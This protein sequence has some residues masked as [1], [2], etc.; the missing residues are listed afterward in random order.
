MIFNNGE[1]TEKLHLTP[2]LKTLT[3]FELLKPVLITF[4]WKFFFKTLGIFGDAKFWA[5]FFIN[6]T[7]FSKFYHSIPSRHSVGSFGT[8]FLH[9]NPVN[10]CFFCRLFPWWWRIRFFCLNFPCNLPAIIPA[11]IH[12]VH[13]R[14]YKICKTTRQ[15]IEIDWKSIG[16]WLK[17]FEIVWKSFEIVW[18][19]LESIGNCL[20]SIGNR[21]EIGLKSIEIDWKSFEKNLNFFLFYFLKIFHYIYFKFD[22]LKI[23]RFSMK[24][25]QILFSFCFSSIGSVFSDFF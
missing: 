14:N 3:G 10:F 1:I 13:L 19:R 2:V 6:L 20:K 16:N 5:N 18:N 8:K 4:W 17:S 15:S 21:L 25:H 7:S 11:I 22:E 9:M 24:F 23:F 12:H